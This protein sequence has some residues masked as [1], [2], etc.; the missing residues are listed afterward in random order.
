MTV[1]V[2]GLKL[3]YAVKTWYIYDD[4]NGSLIHELIYSLFT[5]WLVQAE[6]YHF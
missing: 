3:L 2:N 6:K 1:G 5:D 4:Y